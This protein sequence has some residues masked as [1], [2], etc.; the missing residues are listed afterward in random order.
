MGYGDVLLAAGMA[1]RLYAEAPERGPLVITTCEGTPRWRPEWQGNPAIRAAKAPLP[2]GTRTLPCGHDCFPYP[3]T[4]PAGSFRASEH[5]ATIYFTDDERARAQAV[6]DAHGAFV[7]VEPPAAGRKNA[8]RRWPGWHALG[9]VLAATLPVPVLQLTGPPHVDRIRG[10]GAIPHDSFRDACAIMARATLCVLPEGGITIGAGCVGAAAVVLHGG[11]SSPDD[12]G[13]PEHVNLADTGPGSPCYYSKPCAHCDAI[14][15]R[16]TVDAVV[17]VVQQ[18][19]AA[20]L[21][22]SR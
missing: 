4:R 9:Q 22:A 21:E 6:V 17:T 7:L 10:L 11:H 19:L 20:R 15:A 12:F 1:Q 5:R 13:Y 3:P 8:N 14:W 18:T 16:L 2:P